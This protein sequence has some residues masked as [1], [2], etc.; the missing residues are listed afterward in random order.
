MTTDF[1]RFTVPFKYVLFNVE[2]NACI[3]VYLMRRLIA[4]IDF[5][6]VCFN[7]FMLPGK[8]V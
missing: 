2:V 7:L 3:N 6:I 4:V 1:I 5:A 8:Q